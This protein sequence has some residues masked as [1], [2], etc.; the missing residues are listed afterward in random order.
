MFGTIRRHSKW[1]WVIIIVV[2]IIS[3][4][5][6]FT[7]SGLPG[8]GSPRGMSIEIDGRSFTQEQIN[9]AGREVRVSALIG[10]SRQPD[11]NE[12]ASQRALERLLLTAKLEQYGI[13]VGPEATAAWIRDRIMRDNRPFAGLTFEQVAKQYLEPAGMSAGDL[14]SFARNQ[15]G[16]E[17]L[18]ESIGTAAGLIT[19]QEVE[20]AYRRDNEKLEVEV[21]F[22]TNSNYLAKVT[23][24][25]AEVMK[26]YSNRVAAYRSPDRVQVH[27]V[28]F[29][30][31]NNLATAEAALNASGAF[32]SRIDQ[33][34]QQRGTNYYAGLAEAD[35]KG[36]IRQEMID[37]EAFQSAKR[38]A[39]DFINTYYE[40]PFEGG[41]AKAA[42]LMSASAKAIGLETKTTKPFARDERLE[43]L[44]TGPEF[45]NAAFELKAEE[46]F[47]TAI[48]A[49]DGYYA[50]CFDNKISGTSQPFDQ[51]KAK[52]EKEYQEDRAR[53]LAREAADKFYLAATNAV[54]SG[55]SFSA[56][57]ELSGFKV[58]KI[59]ALTL[60]TTTVPG[61]TLPVDIR[62]ISAM[63]NNMETNSVSRPQFAADGLVMIRTG[64]RTAPTTEEMS[65]GLVEYR[66]S[67]R[68]ARE[69]EVLN[70]WIMKQMELS[71]IQNVLRNPAQ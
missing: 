29:A 6:F 18:L 5:V 55:Q 25:Q 10:L 12:E 30:S 1:L 67:M 63:A 37:Q 14:T 19:P 11:S 40:N 66:T 41:A 21:A 26:F 38:K 50:L 16:F 33:A 64:A 13:A 53:T 35:A 51:V 27:Y 71:G 45:E 9:A 32:T 54:A 47:S 20:A 52:V 4:V 60:R 62:Q 68:R 70:D 57:A 43:D 22:V 2:I 15:A 8:G 42:E 69:S 59:P 39:Y 7:P 61:V 36:R 34:Y 17:L 49:A 23:L 58:S 31:S 28:R 24:D 3:F 48:S 46:P 56:L 65:S 44:A